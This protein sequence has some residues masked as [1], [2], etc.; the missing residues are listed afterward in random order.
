LAQR[1]VLLVLWSQNSEQGKNMKFVKIIS[2]LSILALFVLNAQEPTLARSWLR[3]LKLEQ[4]KVRF[5]IPSEYSDAPLE[6]DNAA[7]INWRDFF[8]DPY[9]IHLI[10]TALS[11]NQELNIFLQDIEIAKSEVT[12][13]QGEYLPKVG[14]GLSA[15]NYK[16]SRH[17]RDGA[18]DRIIDRNEIRSPNSELNL[19]ANMAWE[20]DIWKK[21][22]NAKDAST[23]RLM[24]QREGRNFLIS[25]LVA[26][27]AR[28]YYELMAL[29]NS[30]K[31][32]DE[33]IEIQDKAFLK[34]KLLKE[35]A[36]ANN[37]AVNRFEAQLLKTKSQRF[38][39]NQKIV[40]KENRLKFLSGLYNNTPILRNSEKLMS[41]QVSE[42]QV[43]VPAQLLKN[44]PDIR[45]K[46]FAIK[47]AKL[48][49][50]SVQA[51]L[52]PSL[53]IKAGLGF[54]A[55]D[56]GLLFSPKSLVYNL[57]GDLMTPLINRKAIIAR[58]GI[59]DSYQTQTVL[60][61]EQTLLQAYTEVLN[62]MSNIKNTQQSFDTKQREVLLLD[63]SVNIANN[64]FQYAKANYVE[65]LL[66][67]EEKLNAQKELVELK[68]NLIGSRVDLY[69]AL[70]G[71]WK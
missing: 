24:A 32:L 48:D 27:I 30:L 7:T 31:I 1:V 45:Q 49:L 20:V 2:H 57:M 39:I 12:E 9:L 71:G 66:T 29:D 59:A 65:V 55:F 41:M 17:T 5:N 43:G 52:Y 3:P 15:E 8:S 10:E 38:E 46:E 19:G 56:P 6:F 68:M 47:A 58:L 34:M 33:N 40:E 14:L 18:L 70:G 11:N 21:L 50:K 51:N 28:N 25:R 42:L 35:Y 13:R 4:K 67:Q 23:L 22:R 37:L 61:Y 60:N 62:Q 16:V 26:E 36:K 64:L 63:D 54:S 53:S 44:R 69:R